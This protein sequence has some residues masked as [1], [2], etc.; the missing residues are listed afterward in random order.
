LGAREDHFYHKEHKNVALVR[1]VISP[2]DYEKFGDLVKL[3]CISWGASYWI[4]LLPSESVKTTYPNS[5]PILGNQILHSI[6]AFT[7]FK[8]DI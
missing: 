5:P 6:L 2:M 3:K 8:N 7:F 1:E 4:K